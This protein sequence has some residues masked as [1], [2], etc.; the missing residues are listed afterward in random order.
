MTGIYLQ[1]IS[2]GGKAAEDV[3]PLLRD[4]WRCLVRWQLY[5]NEGVSWGNPSFIALYL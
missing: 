3:A 2:A 5:A 4:S 1:A